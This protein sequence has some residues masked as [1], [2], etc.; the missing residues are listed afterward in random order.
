MTRP[1]L[2]RILEAAIYA[3]DLDAAEAFYG[4]VLGLDRISRVGD[5]HVFYRLGGGVVLI[6]N[7]ARTGEPPANPALPVPP[8]GARGPGHLC[9]AAERAELDAW[10]AHLEAAGIAIEADFEWPH[11]ARSIYFR[12]PADNSIEIAEPALWFEG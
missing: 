8:H 6:F 10:R 9:L 3:A 2:S 1:P 7:P 5:R 11:G 12:D 4:G